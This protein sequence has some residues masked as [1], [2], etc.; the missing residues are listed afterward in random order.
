MCVFSTEVYPPEVKALTVTL[1]GRK[2]VAVGGK[3]EK[4]C[5]SQKVHIDTTRAKL[6]RVVQATV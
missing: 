5:T 6:I 4:R 2:I 3:A 1:G